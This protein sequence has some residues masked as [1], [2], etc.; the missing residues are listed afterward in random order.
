MSVQWAKHFLFVTRPFPSHFSVFVWRYIIC[1]ISYENLFSFHVIF[2]VINEI[3]SFS[4]DSIAHFVRIVRVR[5][6]LHTR[7]RHTAKSNRNDTLQLP[8]N[9]LNWNSWKK[10]KTKKNEMKIKTNY[11][12]DEQKRR[13]RLCAYQTRIVSLLTCATIVWCRRHRPHRCQVLCYCIFISFHFFR[14]FK[15]SSSPVAVAQPTQ[16]CWNPNFKY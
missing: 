2:G 8:A 12:S 6:V 16:F 7:T 9:H 11:I 1:F 5:C 3:S 13:W 10:W 4:T 14:R 15:S